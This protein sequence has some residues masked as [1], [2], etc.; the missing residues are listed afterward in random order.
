MG[1]GACSGLFWATAP[2]ALLGLPR[3]R[4][5]LRDDRE[6]ISTPPSLLGASSHTLPGVRGM[7]DGGNGAASPG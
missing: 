4:R 2:H 5:L 3:S 7:V 6:G 1:G